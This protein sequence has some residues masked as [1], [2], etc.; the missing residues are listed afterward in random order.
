M[1][2]LLLVFS[3]LIFNFSFSQKTSSD[4]GLHFGAG[5]L[6]SGTTYALVYGKTKNKKKA[7]WYSLGVSTIAGLA[8]EVYDGYII[9]GRFDTSEFLATGAG[10]LTASY[11][12]NIFTG[13]RKKKKEEAKLAS[14]NL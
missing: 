4:D 9:N 14:L 11:A 12:F 10:G 13:K 2:Y 7:F 3:L 1:K 6:I 8:K 5:A